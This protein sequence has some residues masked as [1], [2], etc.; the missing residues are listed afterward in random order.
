MRDVRAEA[1]SAAAG[2]SPPRGP[3]STPTTRQDAGDERELDLVGAH[4]P[5]A[6]DVD[7]LAV[8]QVALQQHL[9]GAA[10]E[11]A[12]VELGLAQHDAVAPMSE[13]R[14]TPRKEVRPA[15]VTSKPVIGG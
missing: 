6:L 12:Q 10:L 14:S 11:G 2:A 4:E 7:Q 1:A 5:R 13:T 3:V 8:E 15:T 9:L